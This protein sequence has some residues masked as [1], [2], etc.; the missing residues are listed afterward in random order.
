MLSSHPWPVC[1]KGS[2][3][4]EPQVVAESSG[5]PCAMVLTVSFA[6]SLVTG[7][8]CHHRRRDAKHHRQLDAS[9]G[10]SGPHDFAVRKLA[11]SSARRLRPPHPALHVRDDRDTPL[12]SR[13]DG[14]INNADFS[15]RRSEIFFADGLDRNS[16]WQPV[17]QISC[18][19]PRRLCVMPPWEEGGEI[20]GSVR[21]L[22]RR[23]V[24]R[25]E[26]NNH[27][28]GGHSSIGG[29]IAEYCCS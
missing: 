29:L 5:L 11:H 21:V 15:K 20:D 17:G 9:V 14:G 25:N 13:R 16:R 24:A 22:L 19:Y 23:K 7:L 4:V 28:K 12:C 26:H 27:T 2:T 8:F 6:L 18:A 10:A 1:K 3:R